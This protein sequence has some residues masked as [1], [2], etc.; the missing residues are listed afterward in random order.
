MLIKDMFSGIKG[1]FKITNKDKLATILAS[2]IILLPMTA[3]VQLLMYYIDNYLTLFISI[4]VSINTALMIGSLCIGGIAKIICTAS[5]FV[6]NC[7][8]PD[9]VTS[10]QMIING[11]K[12]KSYSMKIRILSAKYTLR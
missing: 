8:M 6:L 7:Y 9:I 2:V 12:G 3:A 5:E 1:F 11:F 4:I 10:I